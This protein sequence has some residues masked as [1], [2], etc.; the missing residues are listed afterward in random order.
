[1]IKKKKP[2]CIFLC[3][4]VFGLLDVCIIIGTQVIIYGLQVLKFENHEPQFS[5]ALEPNIFHTVVAMAFVV[6]LALGRDQMLVSYPTK[7]VT[8]KMLICTATCQTMFIITDLICIGIV[9]GAVM[10]ENKLKMMHD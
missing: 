2:G 5:K 1:M 7:E 9:K 6:S 8:I 10:V 3:L 4:V